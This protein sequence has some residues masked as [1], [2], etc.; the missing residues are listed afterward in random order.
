MIKV[1]KFGALD[2]YDE[3]GQISSSM[4]GNRRELFFRNSGDL[5]SVERD[6]SINDYLTVKISNDDEIEGVTT[7][8]FT[9]TKHQLELISEW[10]KL[11]ENEK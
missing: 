6:S 2:V 7:A 10:I 9:I 5:M 8:N 11:T 3:D 1:D 4:F